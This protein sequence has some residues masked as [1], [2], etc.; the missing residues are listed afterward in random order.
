[1]LSYIPTYKDEPS[2]HG[3]CEP[4]ARRS[5]HPERMQVGALTSIWQVGVPP[6]EAQGRWMLHMAFSYKAKIL[7]TSARFPMLQHTAFY[8]PPFAKANGPP[9]SPERETFCMLSF[10]IQTGWRYAV[11]G[12]IRNVFI[13]RAICNILL[14]SFIPTQRILLSTIRRQR[15]GCQQYGNQRFHNSMDLQ[16]MT[17]SYCRHSP[18]LSREGNVSHASVNQLLHSY[19]LQEEDI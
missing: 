8:F 10:A 19:P 17:T 14:L 1:M 12:R 9:F 13:K 15:P 2:A 11:G 4:P 6:A 5:V 3:R 18:S 16:P 7:H